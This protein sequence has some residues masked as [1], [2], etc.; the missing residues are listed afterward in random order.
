MLHARWTVRLDRSFGDVKL[1][2]AACQSENCGG[3]A[4]YRE[5]A[6]VD[7]VCVW[8]WLDRI[9]LGVFVSPTTATTT[10]TAP[11][12]DNKGRYE[13]TSC[14]ACGQGRVRPGYNGNSRPCRRLEPS[15][16]GPDRASF[17][18]FPRKPVVTPAEGFTV[19]LLRHTT[20]RLHHQLCLHCWRKR[21]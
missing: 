21:N 7:Y 8:W 14:T 9:A 16:W 12:M 18:T 1:M 15:Q 19:R 2:Q 17:C 3:S 4:S 13:R 10:A 20:E 11:T 5:Y 6:R